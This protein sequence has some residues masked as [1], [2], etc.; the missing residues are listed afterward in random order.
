MAACTTLYMYM[1]EAGA[2][3]TVISLYRRQLIHAWSQDYGKIVADP[4]PE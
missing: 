4:H 1:I 2:P 3:V